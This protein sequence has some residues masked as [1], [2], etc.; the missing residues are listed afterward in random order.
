M[1]AVALLH[2]D[3]RLAVARHQVPPDHGVGGLNGIDSA[4]GPTTTVPDAA[5]EGAV[6]DPIVMR[7]EEEHPH[8]VTKALRPVSGAVSQLTTIAAKEE[9]AEERV[10]RGPDAQDAEVMGRAEVEQ[11]LGESQG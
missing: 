8:L 7:L 6:E 11:P 4:A 5:P 2:D 10:P 9:D 1:K 3:A